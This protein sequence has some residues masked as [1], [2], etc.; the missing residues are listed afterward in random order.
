MANID[1]K[2]SKYML[3]LL[4]VLSPFADE[5]KKVL[6]AIVEINSGTINKYELITETGQLKLDRVGYS[7]LAYPFAYGAIPKTWDYDGDPLDIEIVNVMEPLVPG[8]LVEAR[9]IGV[10]KFEDAG[11]IDD[12]I[13]AVLADD[14]RS[15]HI[16][17][18]ED[19]GGQF[20]K[21]T[22]YYWEHIKHLK[23]PGTGII[24][25]F[26]D[27]EEAIKVVQECADRYT[28][29]YLKKFE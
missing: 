1:Q 15:D 11:E 28:D 21:E 17:S 18:L 3:N 9:I 12:K 24:K 7:S 16:Q 10:M 6:N 13:I 22:T 23:K 19:L 29:I 26:F 14:R 25:G 8:C 2:P 27:K 20:Q 4:H 5:E